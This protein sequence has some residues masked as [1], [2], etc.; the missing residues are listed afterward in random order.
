M[1]KILSAALVLCLM[2]AGPAFAQQADKTTP[3]N[4]APA[5]KHT[6]S[7]MHSGSASSPTTMHSGSSIGTSTQ[8]SVATAAEM[9]MTKTMNSLQSKGYSEITGLKR[10]GD[11]WSALATKD[12]KRETLMIDRDGGISNR[13]VN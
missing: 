9:D 6:D 2:A 7:K 5:G 8:P 1:T 3:G 13:V 10:E 11:G 4:S 12:G